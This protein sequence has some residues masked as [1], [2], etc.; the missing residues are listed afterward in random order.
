MR[1]NRA[2]VAA[3]SI[4]ETLAMPARFAPFEMSVCGLE[5]L[6]G[7]VAAG[8]THVL[9]ILDPDHPTPDVFDRFPVHMRLELR[10]HD[11]IE[12][13]QEETPPSVADV[14]RI[15]SFGRDVTGQ[16]AQV[17]RLLVHCH[18]GISRSTAALAMILAQA[19][20]ERP[21]EE[22]VGAVAA[23]R[24]KAWPNLRM[25][26]LADDMLGRGGELTA[27]VRRRHRAYAQSNP[28]ILNYIRN[29]GRSREIADWTW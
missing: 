27:A 12:E 15:L 1:E 21:A 14:A 9:S 22:A 25:I 11:V 20:P 7:F 29:N 18:A 28:Q 24:G 2:K 23:V 17:G 8:V 6:P 4:R 10:F 26:E 3:A 13:S 5:E 16:A 19:A